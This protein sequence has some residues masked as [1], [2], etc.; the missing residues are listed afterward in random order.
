[1]YSWEKY[2]WNGISNIGDYN[3]L[4]EFEASSLVECLNACLSNGKCRGASYHQ[5]EV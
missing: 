3:M 1:M 2:V 5:T 4:A